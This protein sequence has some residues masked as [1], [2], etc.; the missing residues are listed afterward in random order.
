MMQENAE[1]I[2]QVTKIC[3]NDKIC[4]NC[5]NFAN[6]T[7]IEKISLQNLSKNKE[8]SKNKNVVETPES[9]NSRKT[10]FRHLHKISS[11]TQ[12]F[13]IYKIPNYLQS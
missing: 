4:S 7:K 5:I 1:R 9:Q 12:N 13:I 3:V 6:N 11:F 2:L 8:N 10:K